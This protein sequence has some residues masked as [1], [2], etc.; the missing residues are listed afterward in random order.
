MNRSLI[1]TDKQ[2]R[3]NITL[4]TAIACVEDTWRWHGEG[5]VVMPAKI[6][7]DMSRLGV[8]GWF[9]S[10]PSFIEPMDS[11]GIKVVGGYKNNP[12]YGMPY[13]KSNILLTDPRN[14]T[15]RALMCGDW[16][17]DARTGAQPALAMKY[18][19]ASTDVLTII[20]A[21]RQAFFCVSC[22]ACLH[23]LKEVRV[24]DIRQEARDKFASYFPDATFKINPY[25]SN[26]EACRGADVIITITTADTALVDEAWCKAGCLVLTM[27]SFTETAE[28]VPEKFDKLFID[29]MAQGLHRGNFKV[30]AEKGIVNENC[31]EAEL[32]DVVAGKKRG[33][34]NKDDR[35]LCELVGMGSP[36]LCIATKVYRAIQGRDESVLSVDMIGE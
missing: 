7:T 32:P 22:I 4:E 36:D 27:G 30:M 35:I 20:G 6:T 19:A 9:N 1:I 13:I 34:T 11:A 16:I 15:L 18:L 29:C 12:K 8:E 31:F 28:N 21:G 2:V 14:G 5:K 23:S 25:S 33:R 10:M 26:E 17:S 3:E 24:C